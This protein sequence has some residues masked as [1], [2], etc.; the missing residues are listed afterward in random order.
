MGMMPKVLGR[1]FRSAINRADLEEAEAIVARLQEEA[2]LAIA[3]RGMELEL[4]IER[5]LFDE[6]APLAEQ[7]CRLHPD[8]GKIFFLAGKLAYR[9]REYPVAETR[10]RESFRLHPHWKS[11]YWLGRTMTALNRFD[12]ARSLLESVVEA[13]PFV[14]ADLA[15]LFERSKDFP[16]AIACCEAVLKREPDHERARTQ[17]ARLKAQELQPED[18]VEELEGL[19]ALGE[20]IPHHLLAGYVERLFQMGRTQEA[21]TVIE[22][23]DKTL[24]HHIRT[25]IAWACYHSQAYDLAFQLFLEVLPHNLKRV[26]F[27]ASLQFSAEKVHQIPLLIE[28]FSEFAEMDRGLFGRIKKLERLLD[29]GT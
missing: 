15:W 11:R 4:L 27:Y 2:P 3:T 14:Q 23:L 16:R 28:R 18:L 8:S 9:Q 6:A 5:R 22:T 10:L 12:E 13:H 29:G 20:T 25:N 7:L 24:Q 21:R 17:L 26:S 1:N 19:N